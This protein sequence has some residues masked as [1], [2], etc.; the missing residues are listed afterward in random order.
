VIQV[1]SGKF[2]GNV[3]SL[4]ENIAKSFRGATF[5]THT[6]HLMGD[7]SAI[8]ESRVPAKKIKRKTAKLKALRVATY[9]CLAA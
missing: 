9:L 1:G 8:A 3:L 7:L 4:S 2:H 6:V 5:F